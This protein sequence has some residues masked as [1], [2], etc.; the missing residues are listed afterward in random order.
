[1]GV[2]DVIIDIVGICLGLDWLDID[3][4]Y[5]LFLFIGGGIVKVVYG[6]LFVFVLVVFKFWE[7]YN[8]LIYSNGLEK[9]LCIFIGSVIVCIFVSSFGLLLLMFL[10]WVG[11]GVGF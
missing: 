2:I 9:E 3:L 11:L 7:L 1:M 8:V 10:E 5:C 6:W 4:L